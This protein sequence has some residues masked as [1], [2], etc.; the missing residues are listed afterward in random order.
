MLL[1]ASPRM[2]SVLA[3]VALVW[4]LSLLNNASADAYFALTLQTWE[5]GQFI[6][7]HGLAQWMGWLWPYAALVYVL[8]RLWAGQSKN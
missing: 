8:S 1:F 3:L 4:Q 7:F 5:R 2:C 6:R